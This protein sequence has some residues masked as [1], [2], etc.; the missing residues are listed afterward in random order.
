MLLWIKKHTTIIVTILITFG[1]LFFL[2]ACEAKTH[3]LTKTDK[4][5]NRQEL[6]FELDQFISLARIRMLDLDKQEQLRAIVLENALILVQGQPFNPFGLISAVAAIYGLT[7]AGS[8]V[9]KKVKYT[10]IKRKANNGTT[11]S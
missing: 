7:K 11:T 1:V 4:L 8:T 2:Y 3:S 9:S 6:Q 10:L 5:V